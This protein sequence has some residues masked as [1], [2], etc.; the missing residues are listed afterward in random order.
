MLI[1]SSCEIREPE[2]KPD[3]TKTGEQMFHVAE[4]EISFA[5]QQLDYILKFNSYFNATGSLKDQLKG[6]YFPNYSIN[7]I[8]SSNWII[9]NSTDTLISFI[10]DTKSFNEIGSEWKIKRRF[11]NEYFSIKCIDNKKWFLKTDSLEYYNR[12]SSDSLVFECN[13]VLQ[14]STFQFSNFSI[15]GKCNLLLNYSNQVH[16]NFE[17]V[18]PLVYDSTLFMIKSGSL[19]INAIELS[20]QRT[21]EATAEYLSADSSKKNVKISID[22]FSKTYQYW[23]NYFYNF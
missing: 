11:F 22:G 16:L 4:S 9:N 20:T 10:T 5:I 1:L 23:E 8:S 21:K 2:E 19:K 15:S 7:Q 13:N 14:P 6:L 17:T 12:I 3:Y 18:T